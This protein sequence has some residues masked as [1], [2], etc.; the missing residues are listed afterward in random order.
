MAWLN[1]GIYVQQS[2]EPFFNVLRAENPYSDSTASSETLESLRMALAPNLDKLDFKRFLSAN[3]R[4]Y[5][6]IDQ[7]M[8]DISKFDLSIGLR[9]HGNMVA[10]QAGCP[11]IWVHH[12]ARTQELVDT[13]ALPSITITQ[14]NNSKSI[15]EIKD[16]AKVDYP[17]YMKK[18][19]ELKEA[20]LNFMNHFG[21]A[22]IN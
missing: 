19:A 20:Y 9:L 14:F 15:Y 13:M 3:L 22:T 1:R 17:L 2:V 16:L 5:I 21:I 6:S 7:W 4:L 18:R 10:H 12:D 11:A 8:E